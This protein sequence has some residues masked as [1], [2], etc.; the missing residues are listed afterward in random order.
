MQ[1]SIWYIDLFIGERFWSFDI[2]FKRKHYRKAMHYG[3]VNYI[4]SKNIHPHWD[5]FCSLQSV[6]RNHPDKTRCPRCKYFLHLII[7][8][9]VTSKVWWG[10]IG[11]IGLVIQSVLSEVTDLIKCELYCVPIGLSL[12]PCLENC[13]LGMS[14]SK[15]CWGG[16]GYVTIPCS[17][18]SFTRLFPSNW[19]HV[20]TNA[21]VSVATLSRNIAKHIR[22]DAMVHR[23]CQ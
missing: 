1:L 21:S 5:F 23:F 9:E 4:S 19:L 22:H 3:T 10:N 20:K 14:L 15:L 16:A 6:W 17:K 13:N 8:L 11:A 12:V 2:L 18:P 7:V